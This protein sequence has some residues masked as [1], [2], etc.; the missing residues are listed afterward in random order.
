MHPW[1]SNWKRMVRAVMAD[2]FEEHAKLTAKYVHA[3]ANGHEAIQ[4]AAGERL[5]PKTISTPIIG[6]TRCCSGLGTVPQGAY[7]PVVRRQTTPSVEA[8]PLWPSG[9]EAR[10]LPRIPH[11]SSATG[12]QAI[13]ATGAAM[14]L[15][16]RV[17]SART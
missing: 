17:G 10:G 5:G 9:P 7:A 4:L 8:H 12:M 13:P 14:G 11:N 1:E 3:C 16:T 6:T 15:M 2:L